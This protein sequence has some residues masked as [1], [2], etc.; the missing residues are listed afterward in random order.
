MIRMGQFLA[1]HHGKTCLGKAECFRSLLRQVL[2]GRQ[3]FPGCPP[4]MVHLSEMV[5]VYLCVSR[6][7]RA[8]LGVVVVQVDKAQPLWGH[9]QS[10][11]YQVLAGTDPIDLPERIEA[12]FLRLIEGKWPGE[13]GRL[14]H[15]ALESLGEVQLFVD[16]WSFN[17]QPRCRGAQPPQLPAPDVELG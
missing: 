9:V 10:G 7:W 13:E 4:K 3:C 5:P 11:C 14:A 15:H 2:S 8:G 1:S 12:F 6:V 17:I 16:K